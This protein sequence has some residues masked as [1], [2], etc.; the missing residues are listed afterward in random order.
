MKQTL[1]ETLRCFLRELHIVSPP[2]EGTRSKEVDTPVR[3]GTASAVLSKRDGIL[4]IQGPHRDAFSSFILA[5]LSWQTLLAFLRRGLARGCASSCSAR[6]LFVVF[7][8][9][10]MHCGGIVR[11]RRRTAESTRICCNGE[12]EGDALRPTTEVQL[13]VS[14]RSRLKI[15]TNA[16]SWD[17][18]TMM[19]WEKVM[20]EERRC[21]VWRV[22]MCSSAPP[23]LIFLENRPP[24]PRPTRR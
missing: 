13:V 8:R 11:M 17:P 20:S 4:N 6:V 16:R 9:Y 12:V 14:Q 5:R 19:S 21:G 24:S 22:K 3:M 2:N 7:N 10:F 18:E 23:A 15:Y 1:Q